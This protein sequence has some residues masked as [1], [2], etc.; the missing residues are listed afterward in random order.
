MPV[1]QFTEDKIPFSKDKKY[2][3]FCAQGIRSLRL[4]QMVREMG[5]ENVYSI[6]DGLPAIRRS[7]K[8]T[9]KE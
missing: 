4:A 5:F 9:V 6:K 7:L 1:S 3:L 2:L 8:E